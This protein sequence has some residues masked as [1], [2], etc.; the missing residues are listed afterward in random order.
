MTIV[1][2]DSAKYDFAD[3]VDFYDEQESGSGKYF[4][5]SLL[6]D[7]VR[8]Q[9]SAGV[10]RKVKGNHRMICSNHPFAVFYEVQEETVVIKAVFDC[11]RKPSWLTKKLR[12]R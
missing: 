1:F 3:A 8:L 10:H 5:D 12:R 4:Y 11:R 9:V 2:S 7:V 6:A